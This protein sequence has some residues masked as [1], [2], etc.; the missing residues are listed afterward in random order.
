MAEWFNDP[1]FRGCAF[2]N[3]VAEVGGTLA[4]VVQIAQGH[5]QDMLQVIADLLP[6][7]PNQA[8]TAG[9]AAL[10]V[11]GTIVRAQM[12]GSEAALAGLRQLLSAL[13]SSSQPI[14]G[15]SAVC[16]QKQTSAQ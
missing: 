13:E 2:I 1:A 15:F 16:A 11:D 6:S 10:A 5:K 3:T 8:A 4:G 9:A 14:A 12:E 7:S